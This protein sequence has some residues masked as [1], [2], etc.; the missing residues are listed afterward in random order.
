M[1]IDERTL[2]RGGRLPLAANPPALVVLAYRTAE[3]SK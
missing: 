2:P 3:T 1:V